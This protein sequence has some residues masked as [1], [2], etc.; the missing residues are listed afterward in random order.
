MIVYKLLYH[1]DAVI[2]ASIETALGNCHVFAGIVIC[3][4]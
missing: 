2:S 1:V 4:I 3:M